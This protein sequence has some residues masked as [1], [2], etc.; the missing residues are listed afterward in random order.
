MLVT[1]TEIETHKRLGIRELTLLIIVFVC[2]C[3]PV[4]LRRSSSF[5][6]K[7]VNKG[8]QDKLKLLITMCR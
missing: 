8:K 4:L 7:T 3:V 5:S 6:L 2:G 1:K